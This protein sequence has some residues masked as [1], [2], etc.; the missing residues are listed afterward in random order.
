M[1]FMRK[2]EKGFTLIEV[3][4][5]VIIIGIIAI[6]ALPKLLVT[7]DTAQDNSCL[8]NLQA[9]R[10]ATEQYKWDNPLNEYPQVTVTAGDLQPLIDE[11]ATSAIGG[12][13]DTYLPV[14]S[15]VSSACPGTGTNYGDYDYD[16]TDGAITC[17]EHAAPAAP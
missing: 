14:N 8:S 7:R 4:L 17:A 11:L 9:L 16:S 6:I 2:K 5:V 3:M 15:D 10:T 12:M 1:T 13:S